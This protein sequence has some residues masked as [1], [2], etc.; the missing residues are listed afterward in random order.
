MALWLSEYW[1]STI[2]LI[3]LPKIKKT[4]PEVPKLESL[5][6]SLLC[7]IFEISKVIAL[8]MDL[9]SNTSQI[10]GI[11]TVKTSAVD[12]KEQNFILFVTQEVVTVE[13]M[14]KS[15][16]MTLRR[17]MGEYCDKDER[18]PTFSDISKFVFHERKEVK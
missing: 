8:M 11:M 13:V 17:L 15:L 7:L 10:L 16:L 9:L 3:D 14:T 6:N 18:S 2:T 4:L 5:C 12:L 1:P